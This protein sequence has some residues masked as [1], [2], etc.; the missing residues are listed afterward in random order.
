MRTLALACSGTL[1][2]LACSDD[3]TSAS[4]EGT[5]GDDEV[6]TSFSGTD[7]DTD[8][9]TG[10]DSGSEDSGEGESGE[11]DTGTGT[12]GGE[13]GCEEPSSYDASGT[14]EWLDGSYVASVSIDDPNS[15]TRS[16]SL[17]TTSPL[18]DGV[19]DNPRQIL[20]QDTGPRLRSGHDLFDALY[21][22][23]MEEVG[24]CSVSMITD[25]AFNF[26]GSV[27][28]GADGCFETGRLW[29]YVWTRDTAYAMD[30]GLAD[31]DPARARNSLDFKLS[32]RR[33]GGDLQIVQDTGSGGSYPVSSDRVTWALGAGATLAALEDDA[34][35]AFEAR[36]YEAL[37]NTTQHD[38]GIVFD[39]EDGLY[40]GEQSFLDW[41]EQSYPGWTAE[42]VVH[43]AQSKSLSTN[44]AHLAAL[45]L[46][47][48]LAEAR[49]ETSVAEEAASW[50][51]A[52]RSALQDRLWIDDLG[53]FSSHVTTGLDPA[54]TRRMDLLGSA[55]AILLD[56]AS[57]AQ[58]Q[59]I[60]SGY[61]HYGPGA[62]VLWPQQQYT[63]IYHNRGEWPFVTAY[64]LRAAAHAGHDAVASKMIRALI[65]GAAL[66]LSNM[67]NFEAG[68]GAV[69]VDEG[70]T[71]GPVVN[72]QRQLWSVAAYVS[73]VHQVLF[74][75]EPTGEGLRVEPFVP[76]Q[77]RAE[78]FGQTNA[79]VLNDYPLRGR[80]ITVV[81]NLPDDAGS[82]ALSVGERRV[83]GQVV[84]ALIPDALLVDGARVEVDLAAG[85]AAA[86]SLSERDASDYREVFGPRTPSIS[87]VEAVDGKLRL[88]F[89]IAGESAADLS[90]RVYRDGE[91]VAEGLA[92]D[93][94][95]WTDPDS[96]A[97]GEASPCYSVAAS[98]AS[99]N[100]SQHA[101]PACWW[102]SDLAHIQAFDATNFEAVGGS[103][104]TNWG[105]FHYEGWGAA[106]DSLT[107]PSFTAT[108]GGRHLFQVDYG[109]GAGSVDTGITCAVKRLRV[110][111][112]SD[113][114]LVGEGVLV[115]PHL[116]SWDRW[117]DSNLVAVELE[118]GVEYRAVIDQDED[119]INM[120]SFSHFEIYT[121]GLGGVDGAYNQVNIAELRV[122]AKP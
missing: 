10:E 92:G 102:G 14:Q 120:S 4:E 115:M 101:S 45:E 116:G 105:R 74:G 43:I 18:R 119:T 66:N 82:G 106:G 121:G 9:G 62:P 32:E 41:R 5:T 97:A 107:L 112:V 91:L 64:W 79:L 113:D 35:A 17:S 1:L 11:T 46:L 75:L 12:T 89:D 22:L 104:V 118:A 53:Q 29:H 100:A 20:E 27:P 48:E 93:V 58:A 36:A 55:L 81:L 63:P 33:S 84:D 8:A 109:N 34:R 23:A 95:S 77:V 86:T 98:Y 114:A 21:A 2:L 6:G 110:E 7:T 117:E 87:A 3:G 38:R 70:D 65:R 68:S 28:C 30:L 26:G 111:R 15:C 16:Y 49:G 73:M 31:L 69:W 13:L 51:T 67:E 40:R 57:D 72:S 52:L 39:P 78:I 90:L 122:L 47:A 85:S 61:P 96:A 54:P 56:V 44:L 71:S 83:D 108:Q 88:S 59:E 99:G 80:R 24:E 60:L 42:D 94:G 19:P 76:A 50:A 103:A 25:Y 37:R